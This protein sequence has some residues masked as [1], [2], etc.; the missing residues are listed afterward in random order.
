MRATGFIRLTLSAAALAL[1]T[2]L[3]VLPAF[4][5]PNPGDLK[6]DVDFVPTPMPAVRIMLEMAQVGPEDRLVDLGSGDG[7]I[8]VTAVLEHGVRDATGFELDGWFVE[9]SNQ[10]AA[11]QGLSDYVRFVRAD[12]FQTDFADADVVTMYL[13]PQLNLRLRPYL[14]EQLTPGTR[15]VSHSFDMDDWKPDA[16]GSH[17]GRGIY[18]WVIPARVAGDWLIERE[19]KRPISLSLEQRF[20]QVT[21][22]AQHEDAELPVS[23]VE[24]SGD[25]IRFAI[26]GQTYT[27]SVRHG[28]MHP[29]EGALWLATRQ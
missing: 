5:Q 29:D 17:L 8:P 4:A 1:S 18:L 26:D 20:Q 24:L 11:E 14:L 21:A 6:L 13:L 7:R 28:I 25:R 23:G 9:R 22:R 19:G 27:A 2:S 12:I 10:Q 15:V 3:L 16:T